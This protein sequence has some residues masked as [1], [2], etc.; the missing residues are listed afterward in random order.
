MLGADVPVKY[1]GTL[2]YPQIVPTFQHFAEQTNA[3]SLANPGITYALEFEDGKIMQG[4]MAHFAEITYA[5]LIARVGE[6][7]LWDA[8]SRADC[9]GIMNWTMMPH[10]SDILEQILIHGLSQIPP[11]PGRFFIL[12][13]ADPQ[14]RSRSDLLAYL[15]ILARY[16]AFGKVILTVNL[17]EAGEIAAALGIQAEITGHS[18][19][20]LAQQARIIRQQLNIHCFVIHHSHCTAAATADGEAVGI[21]VPFCTVPK[22]STGAGDH[23]NAGFALGELMGFTVREKLLMA[24]ATSGHY[25][26]T[27]TVPSWSAIDNFFDQWKNGT[28]I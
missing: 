25:V 1:I 19:D 18:P 27:A 22:T 17:K 8:L 26:R 20:S 5:Q 21:E 3:L 2:G 28:L 24:T 13:P 4:L 14:K 7:A 23:F 16:E 11:H 6:G 15:K 12:D 10:Q 9:I